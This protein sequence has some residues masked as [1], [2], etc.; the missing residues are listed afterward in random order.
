MA[1]KSF[2]HLHVHTVYS[3]LDGAS[4]LGDLMLRVK[5]L[6]MSSV[7][8]TDHGVMYGVIEFYKMAKQAGIHPVIGCEVYVAQRTRHDR[9]ARLDDDPYHLVLLAENQQGYKNLVRLVSL[10]SIEGFY[11]KPRVDHELLEQYHEGLIA[12]S[13]CLSG[14]IPKTAVNA[15]YDAA[16]KVA[17]WYRDV[18]GR[19]NFYLELQDNGLDRQKPVNEA[20]I[21]MSKDLDIPVVAT[22]DC[23]YIK[24]SDALAQDVLLAIQTQK[25]VND[26]G[27]LRFETS[28][29]YLKSP[30]EM[31]TL[32]KEV[33]E[34]LTNSVRIAE[35]CQIEFE[36]GK[37]KLPRYDLPEGEDAASYLRRLCLEHLHDRY[38]NPSDEVMRRLEYELDVITRM[39]Y[40]GYFL[41][42]WD[43]IRYAKSK[44]I[45]VGPGRGSAAGSLVAYVLGVTDI[46]P[47]K[48]GLLFE[49][50]LNPDRVTLPD[51]DIDFC[52]ERRQE[53][54]EYVIGKYGADSVAQ[55][56]TFGTMAARAVIRDVG[57]ALGMPYSEVD[58]IAKMVP[59]QTGMT[60]DR[61]LDM[62]PD[63][64]SAYAERQEVKELVDL[65]R[66]LEGLPRH[67]S[68]HA[69]GV[70]I[71][72]DP[73]VDQVPLQKMPDGVVVTQFPMETLEELGLLKMDFLG[74]RTLTLIYKAVSMVNET[75]PEDKHL[76]LNSLPLDD[77]RTYDLL[78]RGD[79]LGIF[80]LESGWVSDFLKEMGPKVFEDIIATVALCR[81]GPM[82]H[83][84]E[85]LANRKKGAKYP[86]PKLEPFLRDT[87]GIM[88]YQEQII[89]VAAAVA[90]FSLSR[91]DLL[92]RAVAK[93][94]REILDEQRAAFLEGC[95]K[96]GLDDAS[97]NSIYD[98]IMKFAN[99]GFNRSHAAAYALVAYRTAYLKANYPVQFMAALMTSVMSSSDKVAIYVNEAKKMGIDVLPP[100][101]NSSRAEF[102]VI[103]DEKGAQS[104]R[105]G[106][107]AVKNVGKGTI[108]AIVKEREAR[109]RFRS[110]R[111]FCE[112]VNAD[113]LNKRVLESLIKCGAFDSLGKT[114]AQLLAVLDR[115][116]EMAQQVQRTRVE[117]QISF[118]DLDTF[119]SMAGKSPWS[120]DNGLGF[121]EVSDELPDIKEFSARELLAMEKELLGLYVSGHPLAEYEQ[122]IA[123]L[124]DAAASDLPDYKDGSSVVMAGVITAEK[125][126][127]TKAGEPMA[128]VTL[129]DLTGSVEV[130]VF[131]KVFQKRKS[132]IEV[133]R[134]VA[135]KGTASI[136]EEGEAKVL[137]DDLLAL[138]EALAQWQSFSV[139]PAVGRRRCGGTRGKG[140][141]SMNKSSGGYEASDG[142]KR[143]ERE[144]GSPN[145]FRA[146]DEGQAGE[147]QAYYSDLPFTSPWDDAVFNLTC[148]GRSDGGDGAG[149]NSEMPDGSGAP[150]TDSEMWDPAVADGVMRGDGVA[151]PITADPDQLSRPRALYIK[152]RARSP[153]GN[154]D[155]GEEIQ[156]ERVRQVLTGHKGDCPVYF[157]VEGRS[158][159]V[160]ANRRYWVE[161]DDYL[162]EELSAILGNDRVMAAAGGVDD[163]S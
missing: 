7:A 35:R 31:Y 101:V 154:E 59:F 105:F 91:A 48:Y 161:V 25:S 120:S 15:G 97:A 139:A 3:L 96:N 151:V 158:G 29:F 46:D 136:Q 66:A 127:N 78:K 47:L 142:G 140:V 27:R 95:R 124:A 162:I 128:F 141:N 12:M 65:A 34:A 49:R 132:L 53:V 123:D 102:T 143:M 93:K 85:Y 38:P 134:V 19:E 94:K 116:L 103:A 145:A 36:F 125:R 115:T 11:Y 67:A 83:I 43:F 16:K 79:T 13:A 148:S 8:I 26:P 111:D 71:S 17:S 6:G 119:G 33:P 1:S 159:M 147:G 135:V 121:D 160:R 50:F 110:L 74:L 55:I 92:R 61:A 68:V 44:R 22:N 51:M 117:G 138:E 114:R 131:P 41:I 144:G 75:L 39:G 104:I 30:D 88:I 150:S 73:L 89:Q 28:E 76:D 156:F 107:L 155:P 130:V 52:V 90:G 9:E 133:D 163:V 122:A 20:L 100:D 118:F 87:Y 126:I 21:R 24:K 37:H 32:F 81:P 84:P 80:Q 72:A 62:V 60:L 146:M 108:D 98:L 113:A 40:P 4:R 63:L 5:E 86:H 106:L 18:F 149:G 56:I 58:K 54:I 64:R 99:Y 14:E 77:R 129:E 152:I 45:P 157:C 153:G 23:H 109:G 137:A 10:A 57:R 2:A 69:A 70:V 112:R 42:V 82:E